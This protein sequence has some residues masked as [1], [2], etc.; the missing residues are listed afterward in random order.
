MAQT[1][2]LDLRPFKSV[3]AVGAFPRWQSRKTLSSAPLMSTPNYN[4]LQN[5]Y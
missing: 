3:K 2:Y 5:K 4:N 1:V